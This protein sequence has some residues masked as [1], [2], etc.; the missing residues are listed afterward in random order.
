MRKNKETE[1]LEIKT[2]NGIKQ[3]WKVLVILAVFIATL[4][5]AARILAPGLDSASKHIF[6]IPSIVDT[7]QEVEAEKK[8]LVFG[9]S[10]IK[11]GVEMEQLKK[12]VGGDPSV[13]ITK[14]SPVGT[15]VVDWTYLYKRYFENKDT[16]PNVIFVGFVR[17]HVADPAQAYPI[18]NRRL[19]RH[20]LAQE[21]QWQFW[22]NELPDLHDRVQTSI[23]HY[24]ALFGDQPEHQYWLYREI[25]PH[26]GNGLG[27][28][29][30]WIEQWQE[31]RADKAKKEKTVKSEGEA[32]T[33]HRVERFLNLMQ[34]HQV[35]VYFI[36]M[37][38]PEFY[39]LDSKLSETVTR[40]GGV[41]LDARNVCL[42]EDQYSD[43]YHLGEKGKP[44]FTDWLAEEIKA[45]L[46]AHY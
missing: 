10:L 15:T 17:H 6:E 8:I 4:E 34:Q 35:K 26:Y 36:P 25:I 24:S 16:H 31:D 1:E 38:Q 18:R 9:N 22:E 21:D 44:V 2:P 3:E 13:F 19:G 32:V 28:N 33:F 7:M 12:A 5:S 23:S 43:G 14:V 27:L 29:K 45:E 30:E 40:H 41:W 46:K 37:P 20:F 39:E 42:G 11:H